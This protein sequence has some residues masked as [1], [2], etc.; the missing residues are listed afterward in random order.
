MKKDRKKDKK[1]AL[2]VRV[3][4]KDEGRGQVERESKKR[5]TE[6]VS[7]TDIMSER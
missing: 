2:S 3:I 7:W 5:E 6:N 1:R 4:Q